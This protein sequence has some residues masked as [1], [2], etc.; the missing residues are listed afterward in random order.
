[1]KRPRRRALGL[2]CAGVALLASAIAGSGP[3]AASASLTKLSSDPFTNTSSQHATEVEPD[4][5]AFGSTIVAVAQA[6]R[7]FDG[8]SSDIAWATST[9]GGSTWTN[10]VLPGITKYQGG[11]P[12]DRVSDPSV[13]YDAAHGVWL[14]ESLAL[15]ETPTVAGVAVVV[16]RSTDGGASW[17]NPVTVA[18]G[19]DLDKSWI[20][21]DNT[22]SS[23]FYGH[24]YSE[25][26]DHGEANRLKM[27]TS[28]NG[29]L[30]WGAALNT[31]DAASGLG[32]QPLVQPN[33]QVIVPSANA[34]ETQIRSFLST[35]GGGSWNSTV[36]VASVSTHE[37]AGGLRTGPL[38]S[39]EIDHNGKVYVVW[40]DCRFR[41]SCSSNDIVM[42][43]TTDGTTW[44]AV[45]QIPIDPA[46]SSVDHFIP[47]LAVDSATSGSTAH[48]ALAYYSYPQ[49]S[50]SSSTCQL[51]IGFV[52]S[53]DGGASWSAPGQL[54]GPLTLGWLP[55]TSQG[56]MVG[57]YISTSF[58]GGTAQPV[59]ALAN[60]PSGGV[61]DE[62][63]YTTAGAA[64][65]PPPTVTAISPKEGPRSGG[66]TVSITGT[67][68]SGATAV[69]FG[70]TDATS[71]KVESPTSIRAV[72][73]QGSGTVDVTVTAAGGTSATSAADQY[74]Y[75]SLPTVVTAAASSITR[76]S[77]TLNA[78]VNPEG[79]MVSDCHFEY[80]TT[81]AYGS[82]AACSPAPGSGTSPVAVSAAVSGLTA[83]T[84]YHFRISA[85]NTVGTSVGSDRTFRTAS[86]HVYKNGVIAAEGNKLRTIGWG[87][88]KF[89]N[90]TLG[91]VECH[92]ISAGY[93]ENPAGGGSAAGKLQAFVAYECVS[94][95]CKAQGGTAIAVSPEN[96][97]WST[98]VTEAGAFR[99]RTGTKTKAGEGVVRVNCV[100]KSN[101]TFSGETAPFVLNN[102][103]SI[104]AGPNEEEFDQPGSGELE[105][106]ALGGLKIAGRLKIHGY[107][108][109][110]LIEVKSL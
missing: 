71:F 36:L 64:P 22:S 58:V 56:R 76:T 61:F 24:C 12:Y 7:F 43:T 83:N 44:S 75:A 96:L 45:T 89:T 84:A 25:W 39:A 52:S 97:P 68:F 28:A 82:S 33:G 109:Q 57:D 54:A 11:G 40:Q 3:A 21:C 19:G 87:T 86:P 62:A 59:F 26:D 27:S 104:G 95:S 107:G 20:V 14:T 23:P 81:T 73:P 88:L 10:G 41:A 51:D 110:E 63:I 106:G 70:S 13:A 77:A 30:S 102:G 65:P 66:T 16:S 46:T 72:S 9:N 17:S 4:S 42:S 18:T 38:P 2:F 67:N 85:T 92:T 31:G 94:E 8:G 108:A 105:G 90:S 1:M 5:F 98:E 101:E 91:E 99:M 69:R 50:C 80:G 35:N 74:V 29:G 34:N 79:A 32:G 103:I 15:S 78:T 60:A 55:N 100:G 37:V 93:L 49:A 6:G 53:S 48:L 47:G